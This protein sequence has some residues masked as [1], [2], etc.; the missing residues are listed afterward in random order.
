MPQYTQTV[1]DGLTRLA[2]HTRLAS[3]C[4]KPACT[5]YNKT[6][7]QEAVVGAE[8]VVVCLGTGQSLEAEGHDRDTIKLAGQQLQLLQDAVLFGKI[9]LI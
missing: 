2:D 4:T 6:A 8:F 3:G 9:S 5:L 1:Y 7:V